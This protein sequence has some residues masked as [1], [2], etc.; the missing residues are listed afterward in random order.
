MSILTWIVFGLVVG[1]VANLLD[2]RPSEGGLLGAAV[3][4]IVGAMVGGFLGSLL[5][6][7]G[8]SGLNFPS[9]AVAVLGSLLLLFVGRALTEA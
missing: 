2:P 1:A 7:T 4:G 5:F 8:V 9:L 3:L 6:G